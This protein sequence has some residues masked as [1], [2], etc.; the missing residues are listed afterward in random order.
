MD[1]LIDEIQVLR[2]KVFRIVSNDA[3]LNDA[4]LKE[5]FSFLRLKFT[6][7]GQTIRK[8]LAASKRR[9]TWIFY[10]KHKH[11]Y[12]N[13]KCNVIIYDFKNRWRL[14]KVKKKANLFNEKKKE[15]RSTFNALLD[16]WVR[17]A[18]Q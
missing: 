2:S 16:L 3:G 8:L 7:N 12:R 11:V 13:C 18:Y 5:F 1:G 15:M 14:K 17:G 4:L 6:S 10:R 9:R